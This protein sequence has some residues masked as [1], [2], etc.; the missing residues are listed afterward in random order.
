MFTSDELLTA[1]WLASTYGGERHI[2]AL[3]K[4][5]EPVGCRWQ[6]YSYTGRESSYKAYEAA[7]G[8]MNGSGLS[9]Q[10]MRNE[11]GDKYTC[12]IMGENDEIVP[13]AREL[14]RTGED[15]QL[16]DDVA[17]AL[18]HKRRNLFIEDALAVINGERSA[19]GKAPAQEWS[20]G[21]GGAFLGRDGSVH[22][23]A[24]QG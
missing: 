5:L 8:I 11:A 4:L 19:T 21:D 16:S 14:A 10:R 2:G 20:F 1:V 15:M 3:R 6:A 9:L 18:R 23:K 22:L 12:I 17:T 24:R 7:K 13:V